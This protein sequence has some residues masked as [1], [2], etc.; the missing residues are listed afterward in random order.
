MQAQTVTVA[1]VVVT[2]CCGPAGVVSLYRAIC[3]DCYLNRACCSF[4]P[5]RTPQCVDSH[6]SV[7]AGIPAAGAQPLGSQVL[8]QEWQGAAAVLDSAA[9]V[10]T[11]Q[12]GTAVHVEGGDVQDL[13][14]G[15]DPPGHCPALLQGMMCLSACITKGVGLLSVT[16]KAEVLVLLYAVTGPKHVHAAQHILLC[17]LPMGIRAAALLLSMAV[18]LSPVGSTKDA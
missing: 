16:A 13:Q 11:V 5:L 15:R 14:A 4:C 8:Q 17:V 1:A 10:T 12:A 2:L 3:L 18:P 6:C 7:H 9:V